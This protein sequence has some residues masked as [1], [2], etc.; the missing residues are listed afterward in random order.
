MAR[1]LIT[2]SASTMIRGSFLW[3]SVFQIL[4]SS[5]TTLLPLGFD[6]TIADRYQN[7]TAHLRECGLGYVCTFNT[8]SMT[9]A[10]EIQLAFYIC[11]QSATTLRK[12]CIMY[13]SQKQSGFLSLQQWLHAG[14]LQLRHKRHRRSH[15]LQRGYGW[16]H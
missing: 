16:H 2:T 4:M 13:E 8:I 15:C 14:A 7:D 6:C 5:I 3:S 10:T 1:R 12:M 9:I 11:H